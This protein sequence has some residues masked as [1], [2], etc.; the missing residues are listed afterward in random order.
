VVGVGVNDVTIVGEPVAYGAGFIALIVVAFSTVVGA[1]FHTF[2][3]EGG[4]MLAVVGT[5]R[6]LTDF[7]IYDNTEGLTEHEGP[8][9]QAIRRFFVTLAGYLSPPLL[10]L[11]G[12]ALIAHGNPWAVLVAAILFSILAL[13]P[14]SNPLAFTIPLLVVVGLGAALLEGSAAVQAFTATVVVWFLLISGLVESIKLP[15]NDGDARSLARRTLVPGVVWK[16]FWFSTALVALIVGG[17]LLLRP[18]YSL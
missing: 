2:A 10:G 7:W 3:H 13:F 11:A 5:V 15:S 9:G 18:G 12:A 8:P 17:Q 1:Y 14:A 6:R 16:L 4:H